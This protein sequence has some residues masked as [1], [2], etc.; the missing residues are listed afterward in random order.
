MRFVRLAALCLLAAP[1][2]RGA[3]AEEKKEPLPWEAGPRR[4]TLGHDLTL[5]LPQGYIALQRDAARKLMDRMGNLSNENMIGLV[6]RPDA[7][8]FISLR[9]VDDGYVRDDEA[10]K[11][12]SDAIL[13]AIREGT[14][15]TNKLRQERGFLPVKVEG[16][17]DLP[18]YERAK[19]Q[20][21]WGTRL[22]TTKGVSL[23]YTTRVLGRRGLASITLVGDPTEV[24]AAKPDLDHILNAVGFD[25]G[26]RYED[27]QEGKDKVA[28][29]GLAALIAGGAGAAALKLA[30]VGLLAKFGA[31]LL[32]LLVAGKKL[33]IVA[34]AGLAAL[35]KKLFGK[36]AAPDVPPSAAP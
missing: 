30:K 9:Y 3:G 16:W 15:E 12:D 31:K 14:E 26:A 28:E 13:G 34:L 20:V 17:T 32:A 18:R 29:Y 2:A 27:F 21:I 25:P 6:T 1:L 5:E 10:D 4:I 35:L 33:V 24:P 22:S 7:S 11:L 8:W 19:H 36:K 23:N